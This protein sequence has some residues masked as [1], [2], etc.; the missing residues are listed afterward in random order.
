MN[1]IRITA[2]RLGPV[3]LELVGD[4]PQDLIAPNRPGSVRGFRRFWLWVKEE[5]EAEGL[6]FD[7]SARFDE[8]PGGGTSAGWDPLPSMHYGILEKDGDRFILPQGQ[9]LTFQVHLPSPLTPYGQGLWMRLIVQANNNQLVV[10]V[11]H[12][13]SSLWYRAR[14]EMPPKELWAS[15]PFR[16]TGAFLTMREWLDGWKVDSEGQPGMGYTAAHGLKP[17]DDWRGDLLSPGPRDKSPRWLVEVPQTL[18]AFRGFRCGFLPAPAVVE[19]SGTGR[20]ANHPLVTGLWLDAEAAGQARV[21]ARSLGLDDVSGRA[22]ALRA[23]TV[24]LLCARQF[25]KGT[26][27]PADPWLLEWLGVDGRSEQSDTIACNTVYG[28]LARHYPLGL[29]AARSRNRVTVVPTELWTDNPIRLRLIRTEAGVHLLAVLLGESNPANLQLGGMVNWDGS[30][31]LLKCWAGDHPEE[32][33]QIGKALSDQQGG[34]VLAATFLPREGPS[35]SPT[36]MIAGVR[37]RCGSLEDFNLTLTRETGMDRFG[38]APIGVNLNARFNNAVLTPVS[39]D[40]EVGFETQS[41]WLRRERPMVIDL[42]DTTAEAKLGLGLSLTEQATSNQSRRL[43]LELRAPAGRIDTSVVVLDPSPFLVARVDARAEVAQA[44]VVAEYTDD[45]DQA[46]EWAFRSDQGGMDLV[47][48]PQAIGEEMIKGRLHLRPPGSPPTEVPA[49][50]KPFDFRWGMPAYLK[51]DRTDVDTMRATAPWAIRR[52][53]SI[54]RGTVGLKLAEARFELLY[55]LMTTIKAPGL[56]VAELDAFVGRMPFSDELVKH[57][58]AAQDSD[59]E[60]AEEDRRKYSKYSKFIGFWIADL[61]YRPS[62]WPLFRGWAERES[63]TVSDQVRF[64]LRGKRHTA[65]PFEPQAYAVPQPPKP[66]APPPLRGGVDWPFQS[67]SVYDEFL[68]SEPGVGSVTGVAFGSL[69]GSGSQTAAFNNGKTLI[70]SDTSQGRLN[71]LTLIR[72]GRIAMLW[73]HARHVIVYERTSR[74][75]PRY[76]RPDEPPDQTDS[77]DWQS[78]AFDGF[79]A[80]RKVREYVEITLPR[81]RYPDYPT[82]FPLGGPLVQSTFETLTIPVK[83]GWGRDIPKGWVMPLRGPIEPGEEGHFP[84]PKIFLELARAG[85]KGGGSVAHQVADPAQLLFFTSTRPEDGG[86]TDLW[87]AWPD[88]D[89]PLIRQ[90][91]APNLPYRSSFSGTR[92][93]PDAAAFDFGQGRFTLD[94]VPAEEAVNLLH[95]R[96]GTGLEASVRAVTLARGRTGWQRTRPAIGWQAGAEIRQRGS[97]FARWICGSPGTPCLTGPTAITGDPISRTWPF[98]AGSSGR[99]DRTARRRRRGR[100]SA[101][102]CQEPTVW[103]PVQLA[104]GE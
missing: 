66:E 99:A 32:V 11:S 41:A 62:W 40:P 38:Q 21:S 55:G 69:G 95:G 75:A 20:R 18:T 97:P 70:I 93:Q 59:T 88:V 87:P 39:Q 73:N 92:K 101:R 27:E 22:A 8:L 12:D 104:R 61:L 25:K 13:T 90:A 53:L 57:F 86:N 7:V 80:L 82:D 42:T 84:F 1:P 10:L 24:R 45:A 17:Y 72:L 76:A 51:L 35:E 48:P 74:R 3:Q 4:F 31:P 78:G 28:L 98:A 15:A 56:R 9:K 65:N 33:K 37:V 77:L 96:E 34:P 5:A 54:R 89:F 2:N 91:A 67:R 100:D 79:G 47:L 30:I 44:E 83:A 16:R 58:L 49:P 43:R 50:G 6:R 52:L 60:A 103:F 29:A 63:L 14:K 68:R 64:D 23:R 81:R 19:D 94:L 71:S 102:G 85:G 36:P 46:A 26:G